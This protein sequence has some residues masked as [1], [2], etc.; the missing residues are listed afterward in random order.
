MGTAISSGVTYPTIT[1]TRDVS[2]TDLTTTV[3]WTSDLIHWSDGCSY[4]P[5]GI[6]IGNAITTEVTRN[7]NGSLETIT[8]RSNT[9][10]GT[11]A[12]FLRVEVTEP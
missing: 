10:M 7:I 4:G 8:V 9:P 11:G 6:V 5:A 12:Q 1:F 3:Q 2:I